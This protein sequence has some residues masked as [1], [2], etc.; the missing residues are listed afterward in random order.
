M[1]YACTRRNVD[2]RQPLDV[3]RTKM[4]AD[5]ARGVVR[6]TLATVRVVLLEQGFRG[7]WAGTGPSVIRVGL[8]AGMHFVL[9]EQI[10]WLLSNPGADGA[11][12]LSNMG[13]AMSGGATKHCSPFY[14]VTLLLCPSLAVASAAFY[15]SRTS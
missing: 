1:D 6:G 10:R 5:A 13:A 8:G 9:L 2:L 4:Q 11:L 7:F 14:D 12:Q 3:V 15:C